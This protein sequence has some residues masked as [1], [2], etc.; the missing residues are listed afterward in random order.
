[1]FHNITLTQIKEIIE[2]LSLPYSFNSELDLNF[3]AAGDDRENPDF[4]FRSDKVLDY[5]NGLITGKIKYLETLLRRYYDHLVKKF[6]QSLRYP[7]K[8]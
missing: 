6:Q 8:P 7:P 3:K 1:M 4:Q 2:K 5:S